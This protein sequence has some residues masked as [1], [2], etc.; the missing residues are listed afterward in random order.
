[1]QP[2]NSS[3]SRAS[4]A[5]RCRDK[6]NGLTTIFSTPESLL[7][8]IQLDSEMDYASNSTRGENYFRA[9]VIYDQRKRRCRSPRRS[10][11]IGAALKTAFPRTRDR[12]N[13]PV[14]VLIIGG[15][16]LNRSACSFGNPR[17]Y[18]NNQTHQGENR[19]GDQGWPI[20]VMACGGIRGAAPRNPA[21]TPVTL[22]HHC[23]CLRTILVLRK[24]PNCLA[25]SVQRNDRSFVTP[26]RVRTS[27]ALAIQFCGYHNCLP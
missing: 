21:D 18:R 9:W 6:K 22:R 12:T 15:G 16:V 19:D 20:V 14:P 3:R 25:L 2:K 1:M 13:R 5:V 10:S 8:Q 17:R 26:G 11:A 24:S 4:G 23:G 7:R 27:A